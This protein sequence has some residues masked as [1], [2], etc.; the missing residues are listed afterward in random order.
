MGIFRNCLSRWTCEL[1]WN[2][3]LPQQL[4]GAPPLE[5]SGDLVQLGRGLHEEHLELPGLS[6]GR[7]HQHVLEGT[8]MKSFEFSWSFIEGGSPNEKPMENK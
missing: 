2:S 3:I 4:V 5:L 8:P 7:L 6:L 1:Q